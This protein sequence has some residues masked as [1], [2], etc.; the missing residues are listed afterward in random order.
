MV[1]GGRSVSALQR[2][3]I[4]AVSLL[5]TASRADEQATRKALRDRRTLGKRGRAHLLGSDTDV[6]QMGLK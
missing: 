2:A 1:E 4:D 3:V 6:G 5:T